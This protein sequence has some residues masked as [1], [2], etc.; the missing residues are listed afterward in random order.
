MVSC[1]EVLIYASFNLKKDFIIQMFCINKD[2]PQ[3]KCDGQCFLKRQIEEQHSEEKSKMVKETNRSVYFYSEK[4][5]PFRMVF[6][7]LTK[8]SFRHNDQ[9]VSALFKPRIFQPP[10]HF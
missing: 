3:L 9:I 10:R 8:L 1:Q 6:L 4:I 7:S 5:E 2:K